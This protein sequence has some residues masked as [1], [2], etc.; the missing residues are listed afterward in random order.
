MKYNLSF[1]LLLVAMFTATLS[2]FNLTSAVCAKSR[3]IPD[4]KSAN[5]VQVDFIAEGP[6][7]CAKITVGPFDIHRKYR[8]MEGPWAVASVKIGDLINSDT[9]YLP[10]SRIHY[11]ENESL[12]QSLPGMNQEGLTDKFADIIALG[13]EPLGLN[14]EKSK[15][16]VLYWFKGMKLEVLD[17]KNKTIDDEFLC[18]TNLDFSANKHNLIFPEAENFQNDR[19]ITITQ[20]QS[21][22][23]FPK[24]YA[25]PVSSDETFRISFQAANRTSNVHRKIKHRATFYFIKDSDLVEPISALYARV[26]FVT[27]V[28]DRNNP[29]QASAQNKIHPGCQMPPRAVNAPNNVI[30]ALN[31]DKL[32]QVRS[33]HW[34]VPPGEHS[35]GNPID[36][37]DP[38]FSKK[39]HKLRF[40]W[41][42]IHPCCTEVS[43]SRC[44]GDKQEEL[45]K[46]LIKT[47]VENGLRLV[48]IPL[49]TKPEEAIIFP[50]GGSYQVIAKYNNPLKVPLDAMV[51]FGMYFED[52]KF[53][54]PDWS[55]P[56]ANTAYCGVNS[57]ACLNSKSYPLFNQDKDGPLLT[58]KKR[59]EIETNNGKLRIILDPQLA[60]LSATHIYN[61]L[62]SGAYADT[63]ISRYEE[64]Y[65]LQ[66]SGV[67]D[68]GVCPKLLAQEIKEKL[69]RLPIEIPDEAPKDQ[70]GSLYCDQ[71][72]LAIAREAN[73]LNSGSSS[74]F[75]LLNPAPHLEKQ[76]TVFGKLSDDLTSLKTVQNIIDNWKTK[77][78]IVISAKVLPY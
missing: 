74:F 22:I 51:T 16:P 4:Y 25:M 3:E 76:Y 34:V 50:K 19:L 48:D 24:G 31:T 49:V 13:E 43:V 15:Q 47:D 35:Y 39:E 54:R 42:H 69:R 53:R 41:T 66:F 45:V 78:T 37:T 28:V 61:L 11:V 52:D 63:P 14:K 58:E 9:A 55:L 72:A 7:H 46:T 10:T 56:N 2:N 38:D 23:I 32:G 60:P 40:A 21:E 27:V 59:I 8:S 65:I 70:V 6:T 30:G 57:P 64:N 44:D 26:P 33:G 17:E 75:I 36:E 12:D 68:K 1:T 29:E 77:R 73:D 5:A 67:E 18:H 20:G 62:K 71:Y